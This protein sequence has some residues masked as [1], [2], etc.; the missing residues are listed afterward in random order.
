M[1]CVQKCSC[2]PSQREHLKEKQTRYMNS[3]KRE[4]EAQHMVLTG[5]PAGISLIN[6]T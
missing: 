4:R 6:K 5:Y 3:K 1:M 2:L